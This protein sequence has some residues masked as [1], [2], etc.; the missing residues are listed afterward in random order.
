MSDL[1]PFSNGEFRLYVDT[2][3]TD[4]FRVQAPGLARA[5]GYREAHDLLR[6]I[7]EDEKGSELVRTL[8]GDQRCG[9]VT[10]AGFYR[11]LGQRQ[12]ARVADEAV[13]TAVE[14]FQNWVYREV[15]PAL[16][17]GD[18]AV[19][20]PKSLPE[21]LRAYAA[22]VEAHEQTR[23]E[24]TIVKPQAE[25]WN[26][27]A[28]T[29]ADYSV[30]DAAYILNRDPSIETGQ[31]RLFGLLREWRLIGADKRP[32][33]THAKHVTLRPQTRQ[34]P[35]T[36]ERI[37]AAPQVRVT[38]EGLAYLHKRLGGTEPLDVRAEDGAA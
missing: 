6:G 25:A 21:A 2:H 26:T 31:M 28:D 15:L 3:P 10:E 12:A 8:G 1:V 22:E 32:Y 20:V 16:R 35:I 4:G 9:Y 5:L 36:G 13:R 19:L 34:H 30:R 17:R 14:R 11:A 7:P 37:P 38:V 33:A 29:G 18:T 27:L 24:L 23:A